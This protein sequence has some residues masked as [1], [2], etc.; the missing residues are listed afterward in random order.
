MDSPHTIAMQKQK[1]SGA[2]KYGHLAG[3]HDLSLSDWGPYAGEM[4]GVSHIADLQR[5]HRVDFFMA[6]GLFRRETFPPDTLRECGLSLREAAVDLRY[7][8]FRQQLLPDDQIYANI[9]YSVAGADLWLARCEFVSNMKETW[10]ASLELYGGLTWN[11]P[12]K[13]RPILPSGATWLDAVKHVQLEYAR[14]RPQDALT[15]DGWRRGQARCVETVSGFAIGKGATAAETHNDLPSFG[16]DAG[17]TI[18]FE[19]PEEIPEGVILL[20]AKLASDACL[21]LVVHHEGRAETST[22]RATDRFD[23]HKIYSGRLVRGKLEIRAKGGAGML[24]DGLVFCREADVSQCLFVPADDDNTPIIADDLESGVQTL[25]T[26]DAR[27]RMQIGFAAPGISFYSLWWSHASSAKRTFYSDDIVRSLA[28]GYATRNPYLENLRHGKGTQKFVGAYMMPIPVPAG[29][30]TVIYSLIGRGSSAK[31]CDAS[32]AVLEALYQSEKAR[33]IRV[34][35]TPSGMPYV[36]SQ[37]LLAATVFSH[38]TFPIHTRGANIRHHTPAR[39]YNM[40]Y[41]WDSGFTGLALNEFDATRAIENLNAYVTEPGDT[42]SAFIHHGTPLPIQ[43]LL[44]QDIYNRIHETEMLEFF[45][46]RL[47][48]YYNF[49]CG[50]QPGSLTHRTSSHL[51]MTWDYFYNSGGWDD[52]PPQ[53]EIYKR[54]LKGIAPAV[55]TSYAIRFARILRMAAVRCGH[56]EDIPGLE[57]DIAM[58]ARALQNHSWDEDSGCFSYVTHDERGEP[59]GIFRH[60]PSGRN[61]NLGMDGATPLV[62]GIC[63]EAQQRRLFF[64]LGE[65]LGPHG[66]SIVHPR[67]PYNRRDGYWNGAVW[68]PHQWLFWKSALDHGETALAHKIA[69]TALEV[70]KREADSSGNCYEHFS[71]ATGHGGGNHSFGGLSS[72]VL[73]WFNAYH[74]PGRLTGGFNLWIDK[75]S[76]S[77]A[78]HRFT[79]AVDAPAGTESA[80]LYVAPHAVKSVTCNGLPL[81]TSNPVENVFEFLLPASERSEVAITFLS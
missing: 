74:C 20:R 38:V 78:G 51:L 52:Y 61:Y 36:H 10:D 6:P 8:A 65:M 11:L 45:Y 34:E 29:G 24:L 69:F 71:Q 79:V 4:F 19:I 81:I 63:S 53:W 40:L 9:S 12:G 17:D 27:Q 50:K 68:M 42:E 13:V 80:V 64:L 39:F 18:W 37:Q 32:T 43:S 33:A 67:A 73:K 23:L 2:G 35:S 31:G 75:E 62:A 1:S 16:F 46:P 5:G 66:L 44:Y 48:Q 28:H 59:S 30:R 72:T 41:T 49:L 77:S 47:R 14:P 15:W 26:A 60:G 76:R 56:E 21:D 3:T 58:F 57:A 22:I 25:E 7:Y 55:T 54:G 70:W